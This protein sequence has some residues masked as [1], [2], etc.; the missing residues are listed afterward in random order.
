MPDLQ[1]FAAHSLRTSL[2]FPSSRLFVAGNPKAAGTSL[3]WWLLQ[4]HDIDVAERTA[5]S[6]WGES[7]YFQ[8]VWDGAIDLRYTWDRLSEAEQADA[9]TATDVLAVLP[10]RH[11]VTRTFAAWASKFLSGEP[12]YEDAL[13]E[14]F[15]RLPD[16]IGSVDDIASHFADFAGALSSHV[17]QEGWAEVDV[18]FWPQSALLSRE[19]VGPTL[20]LRQD[21]IA[22]GLAEI[23]SWLTDHD[24]VASDRQRL[25]ETV[26]AYQPSFVT[27]GLDSI[28]AL[29]PQDFDRYDYPTEVPS[30]PELPVDL[31]WVNDVRG[32]NRRFGV[33]H[34]TAV[35]AQHRAAHLEAQLRQ[36]RQRVEDLEH[37]TSWRVTRPL[38]S[39]S[40][41]LGRGTR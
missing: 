18:H 30:A 36:A 19:P 32:R 1:T 39:L 5:E 21:D 15:P 37:S 41:R 38:R 24:V 33:V 34:E 13:P 40:Y 3:R 9:L 27:Q 4:C 12:Y 6:M 26:V 31:D 11:P 14:T 17:A 23:R 10:V 7:A 35:T 22:S 8:T 29:Y 20:L 16:V 2:F 25:N 28:F